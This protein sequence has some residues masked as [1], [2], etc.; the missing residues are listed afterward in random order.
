MA[1]TANIFN[2]PRGTAYITVQ[3]I[4]IYATALVYYIFLVRVLNLSQIG[5][6]SLLTAALVVF[7]TLS[8]LAL[9]VTATRFIS[10]SMGSQNPS[11]AAAV[12]R[13]SLRLTLAVAGPALLL[14]ILASP[15]I[16]MTIFNTSNPSALIVT[17]V[18]SFFLDLTT[19]YGAYFLGLGRYADLAYQNI[20]YFP[21]SRGL[22]LVL[23]QRR[24][25]G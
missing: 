21:L 3:Q 17:F 5:E 1:E 14:V 8:Q 22:G 24:Q 4:V 12:A 18:G 10:A 13:T 9:P 2:V 25:V 23:V 7:T 11:H 15:F 16:G 20:L 19:L 6:I